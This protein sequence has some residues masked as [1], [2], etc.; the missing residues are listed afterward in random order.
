MK[1]RLALSVLHG[2]LALA[3]GCGE[4]QSPV[5]SETARQTGSRPVASARKEIIAPNVLAVQLAAHHEF[6]SRTTF[7]PTEPIQA[8]LY[9][10][11]S[12]YIEPRRIA[13]FLVSD[14][15]VV[16]EHRIFVSANEKRQEFDFRFA[17][18]PRPLGTYQ[19]K[20]I[21]IA[22]SNGKPVLLAQLFLKVE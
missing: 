2:L 19:I 18:T 8:S 20:F 4:D 10:A 14:E 1:R 5:H 7:T 16:E 15:A 17:K 11:D 22:R 9:L 6:E 3:V 12:Y 21:E 13:A